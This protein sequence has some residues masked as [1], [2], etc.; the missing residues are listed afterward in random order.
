[1]KL[2]VSVSLHPI[3]IGEKLR[4]ISPFDKIVVPLVH[5]DELRKFRPA[6]T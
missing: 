3:E 6:G 4:L 1:M 2:I 5:T